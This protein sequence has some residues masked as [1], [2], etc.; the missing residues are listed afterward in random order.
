MNET[1]KTTQ[2]TINKTI[3]STTYVGGSLSPENTTVLQIS[4]K[5]IFIT[6]E[7][8]NGYDPMK[9]LYKRLIISG[10]VLVI[11]AILT[12]FMVMLKNKFGEKFCLK[13]QKKK[14]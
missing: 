3:T 7:V 4:N 13:V 6:K 8:Y 5:T 9:G 14:E 2:T 11:L 1:M 10:I 12:P